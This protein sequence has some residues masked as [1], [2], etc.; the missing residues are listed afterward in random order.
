MCI[1]DSIS[2]C[3][4]LV[5]DDLIDE[6]ILALAPPEAE[7]VHVGKRAGRHSMRQEEI[8]RV[9]VECAGRFA[10]VVRLKGGDPFVFGRGGEEFLALNAAGIEC[11]TVPGISSAIATVSYTHLGKTKF[12]QETLEDKRFNNGE[13]TLLLVCEEG[14]EEFE[15]EEFSG[16]RVKL[17]A[18]EEESDLTPENLEAWLKAADAERVLVEYNGMWMLDSLYGALPDGWL[19]AQEFMFADAGTFLSYNANMR[20]LCYDK[21]CV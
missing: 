20:Q 18:V 7:L 3:D 19:V 13:P 2:A 9:L 11:E 1:R 10:K 5:Y 16:H 12:I 14:I 17:K 15:P 21:R 8:N 6:G 4:C